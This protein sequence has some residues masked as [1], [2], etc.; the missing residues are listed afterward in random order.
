MKF[1]TQNQILTILSLPWTLLWKRV[2]LWK[3]AQN[4]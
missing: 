3:A 1:L 4:E 2:A